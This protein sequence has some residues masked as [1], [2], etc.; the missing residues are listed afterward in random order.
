MMKT[1][2]QAFTQDKERY[3]VPRKVQDVIPIR[4]IWE[5]GIFQVGNRFA[6]TYKFSDINYLVASP[7]DKKSM[8]LSYSELLNSFDSGATTKITINNRRLNR[9]DFEQEILLPMRE[10]GLDRYRREYNDVLLAK[11]TA[12]N[13]IL[14]E[15][16]I[17]I[18]VTK[19]DIEQ[20]RSYFARV[21]SDL[22]SHF[23]ALGSKCTE[24]GAT[25]KLRV[26]H[27][28]YRPGEEQLFRFNLE[29]TIRKGHDFRDCIAPDCISFQKNHYELGDHVG[30]T[31][32]L[33]EYA[34]FISDE[35]ITELMDY[36]RNMMLSIDIIPVAMDE[37]VSDIRK[38]I[39]SVESDITRWQQRQ[40]QSNNFTANIPYDLEQMRS[41]TKE[42]MDDLMSRDQRMMLALVTLTHLADNLEQLDQDTEALQAIGRARG[43][44]FNIL[45]YQQ[46]D[47]LNTVLP[48]GLKRIEATRTLT[49]E[50]T[51]VLMPF[52]S[53]EIQDAGGIYYGVNAVSHNLIVCN[54]GNLLNGNG[55]ITGVSGSGK[56]MA[57]KQEVSA[58]ALSTDHDIIIV[59]PEREYGELVRALGGEVITI[60]ASDP[61]GCHINALDLSEGYG[62]G[63][64]PLV[65]KSEF[66]MSLYEQLM[67]ADKIEPQ[68]K[69]IIDRSVGNIY[70]EYLKSYQG[71]P[72][73]LKDLYDDLMKQVNPEAHRIA[74]ALELFTVGSLNVFS[75]QTNINTKSRI[76]C[77]DFQDLGEN[78]KSVGLLVMLDAIYNRVIQNRREGK[79]THVYIDEIYLFFANG[80]GS[81][82]SITNYSSEFLYKCWKRFRKY[83]ATLT[84]I[85]QNVEE[86]LLSNTARMMFANSEF[87]LMLN[88]ATTD[89]EQ[90]ARLLGASDTQMSYVDNAPAGHGLI[91][92][93]GAIVPFANELP[94]NTELYRL[95]ST[96]PGEE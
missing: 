18:S 16:Y 45:R 27:D 88:Q 72:P 66:I 75:H 13:G 42:F 93:G 59:D 64:E 87:L 48:L 26:L 50:C 21:G 84:G 30:R 17:T 85:T 29:D 70:R 81:G 40:N 63:R 74:L 41:E 36:P 51:A 20:A 47:A 10:D 71:Q 1:L 95:M 6:K 76:L 5:D 57:A 33:R 32:F 92:V 3:R 8:F 14:Q 94:K 4:R 19:K 9:K 39:M 24:L 67:G 80:S 58:L 69:S 31:L 61:N 96:R 43:C 7:E 62:D 25:D 79:Y 65:M 28:F 78:L 60:S 35:M 37:A 73:T 82:H 23:A 77:F 68:E 11:A 12:G 22:T 91:K 90:L 2:K 53:Q 34:S 56:S 89:R 44:Q 52:K 46:E 55:F 54:R 86:C 15:K 49:T 83:G 38:R